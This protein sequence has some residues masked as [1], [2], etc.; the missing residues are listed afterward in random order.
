M[1]VW[2]GIRRTVVECLENLKESKAFLS[3]YSVLE[4]K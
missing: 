2:G 4:L 1:C 3:I